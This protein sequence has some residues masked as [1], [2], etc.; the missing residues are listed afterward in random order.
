MRRERR[1]KFEIIQTVSA[2]G[3]LFLA[4]LNGWEVVAVLA[5]VLIIFGAQKLPGIARGF[6][7]GIFEFR[8]AMDEEASEAGKSFGG[9]YGKQAGEALTPDNQVAEL[10]DPAAFQPESRSSRWWEGVMRRLA[11]LWQGIWKKFKSLRFKE[12][13][14]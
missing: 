12:S 8:D 13:R 4:W 2:E 3:W 6:G 1:P 5:V 9:I 14:S 10:Y 7:R 11:R